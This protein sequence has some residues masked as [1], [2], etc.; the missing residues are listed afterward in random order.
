M[1]WKV[2]HGLWSF[3][4]FRDFSFFLAFSPRCLSAFLTG[5][6]V[7]GLSSCDKASSSMHLREFTSNELT[8][9]D[10]E[11][12]YISRMNWRWFTMFCTKVLQQQRWRQCSCFL[13]F[14]FFFGSWQVGGKVGR[15]GG[16]GRGA[17]AASLLLWHLKQTTWIL[18]SS[19]NWC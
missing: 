9:L 1:G 17:R 14:F 8:H 15:A 4:H 11:V 7:Q 3:S 10:E 5:T 13:F 18:H 19:C 6:T 16:A 12:A 2:G